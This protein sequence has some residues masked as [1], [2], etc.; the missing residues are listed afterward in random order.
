VSEGHEENDGSLK[1]FDAHSGKTKAEKTNE[2][3]ILPTYQT[4][5]YVM[6]R[7]RL[8]LDAIASE[9]H[10]SDQPIGLDL[11]TYGTSEDKEIKKGEALDRWRGEIRRLSLQLL[12]RTPG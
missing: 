7:E 6:I 11:E 4:S 2:R 5:G 12:D 8:E 1:E 9:I 3:P 10:A